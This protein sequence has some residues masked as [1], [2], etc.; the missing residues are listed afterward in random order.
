MKKV[1]IKGMNDKRQITVVLSFTKAVVLF[2]ITTDLRMFISTQ[3]ILIVSMK[4][5]S[6]HFV[7]NKSTSGLSSCLL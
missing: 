1:G 6:L 4:S 7:Q 5:N 2:T 3:H